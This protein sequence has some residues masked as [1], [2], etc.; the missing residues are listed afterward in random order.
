MNIQHTP[1]PMQRIIF[2]AIFASFTT[3]AFAQVSFGI[4][5]GPMLSNVITQDYDTIS[6]DRPNS[7][8]SYVLG[9]FAMIEL[10][11]KL[12][13]QPELLYANKGT[14]AFDRSFG[15]PE[16]IHY[17]NLP[18]L[19]QYDLWRGLKVGVG[20]E[21]GFLLN[22]DLPIVNDF[23]LGIN[24]GA[25][26]MF[27]DRWLVDIRL[28]SGVTDVSDV[29]LGGLFDP[30]TMEPVPINPKTTNRSWQLTLGYRIK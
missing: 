21:L 28:N 10:S 17:L 12:T 15:R 11:E 25:S 8:F 14:G 3:T 24:F 13:L 19:L 6:F 7:R 5:A 22:Q 26:Y 23:D 30:V 9:A 20:P 4:K 27:S 2:T 18:I 29:E 1:I 16:G